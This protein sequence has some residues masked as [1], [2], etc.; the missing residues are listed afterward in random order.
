M[1]NT[2]AQKLFGFRA[3]ELEGRNISLLMPQPFSGRHNT[4]LATYL[5][6][7]PTLLRI[8]LVW[9]TLMGIFCAFS[10]HPPPAVTF[11][12][13]GAVT[14]LFSPYKDCFFRFTSPRV[15]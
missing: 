14:L 5:A 10:L 11:I 1:A 13:C 12:L 3:R 9:I 7:S 8:T 6:V 2:R 4:Y 15:R